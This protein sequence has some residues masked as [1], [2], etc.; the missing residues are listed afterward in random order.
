MTRRPIEQKIPAQLGHKLKM[1][2]EHL[3]YTLDEMAE[4]IGKNEVS[5]RS[6]IHEWENGKREP[7]LTCLLAYAQRVHVSTDV[8]I[9]DQT[10]LVL[11]SEE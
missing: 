11:S 7:N 1:I 6:R 8:L 9:D 10:G 2:R 4:A 3:G 5:R